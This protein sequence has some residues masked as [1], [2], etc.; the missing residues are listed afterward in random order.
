[1]HPGWVDIEHSLNNFQIVEEKI[2]IDS[3]D[4]GTRGS[5]NMDWYIP[6]VI[7]DNYK[8]SSHMTSNLL[9]KQSTDVEE[10]SALY[11]YKQNYQ[12]RKVSNIRR[13]KS[14]NLNVSRLVL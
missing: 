10:Y 8:R 2:L 6:C 1:M 11:S 13:T 5:E 12:Y 3:H 7:K 14:P 9:N 4:Y